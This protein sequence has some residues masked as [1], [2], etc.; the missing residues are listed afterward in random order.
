MQCRAGN[1]GESKLTPLQSLNLKDCAS[2]HVPY[3]GVLNLRSVDRLRKSEPLN[4]TA[5]IS[6]VC[7]HQVYTCTV[8]GAESIPFR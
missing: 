4:I 7:T 8:D 2:R 1:V 3:I 6:C 5:E